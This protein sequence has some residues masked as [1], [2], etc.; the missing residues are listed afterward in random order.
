MFPWPGTLGELR[1]IEDTRALAV[2]EKWEASKLEIRFQMKEAF[3]QL[4]E[5]KGTLALLQENLILLSSLE[6]LALARLESGK[7]AASDVIRVQLRIRE[8]EQQLA[9]LGNQLSK[10]AS[11]INEL[12]NRPLDARVEIRDSLQPAEMKYQRDS[13]LVRIKR[14]HPLIRIFVIQQEMANQSIRLNE[15]SGKPSFGF[16][17]DHILVG[18]RDVEGLDGNGRDIVQFRASMKIPL[19]REKYKAREKEERIRIEALE[20]RKQSQEDR[21]MRLIEDAFTDHTNAILQYRHYLAQNEMARS[22]I[23]MMEASYTQNGK[24]F[25][26]LLQMESEIVQYDIQKLRALVDS[27]RAL[28]QIAKFIK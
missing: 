12:L 14:D 28:N 3:F 10:P 23:R 20:E 7:G 1:Q 17:V 22:A 13:L 4:Y 27:H 19:F 16:G 5:I 8:T 2:R 11:K 6:K 25:D 18:K 26:D 21:F 15:Y 24:A 9:V